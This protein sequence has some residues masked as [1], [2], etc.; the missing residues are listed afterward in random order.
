MECQGHQ[1]SLA[2]LEAKAK[3]LGSLVSN[4]FP[5]AL[6]SI[7]SFLEVSTITVDLL[8]ILRFT[9]QCCTSCVKQISMRSVALVKP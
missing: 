4:P 5:R 7:Q 1:I 3:D 2:D 9:H 6:L 8:K